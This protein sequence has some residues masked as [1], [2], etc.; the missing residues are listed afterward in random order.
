[1][2]FQGRFEIISI[3]S[4]ALLIFTLIPSSNSSLQQLLHMSSPTPPVLP[5]PARKPKPLPKSLIVGYGNWGQCDSKIIQAVKDGVN[6]VIWFS[7][8]LAVDSNK[9]PVIARGLNYSCVADIINKLNHQGYHDT[10]HLISIGGWNSP[11]PDTTNPVSKVYEMFRNWNH[12]LSR[13]YNFP[14]FDGIDWDIEG[15]DDLSSKYNTF[16]IEVLDFMGHFSQLAKRDG[17]IVS[18]APAESYL[19]P[20]TS[21]FDLSLKHEYNEWKGL[22]APFTYHGRNVYGYVLDRYGM[23]DLDIEEPTNGIEKTKKESHVKTFDFVT[24]QLYEGYSHALFQITKNCTSPSKFLCDFT[25]SVTNGWTINFDSV[26]E[27][28]W[29]SRVV[30]VEAERLVIGLANGWANN[31]KFLL[32]RPEQMEDGA[33]Q[34]KRDGMMVRGFAFWNIQDEGAVP[35]GQKEEVWLTKGLNKILKIRN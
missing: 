8:D 10:V 27:A 12:D 33:T 24:I 21:E 16:T 15:N 20:T 25:K 3:L 5:Y 32:I 34:L 9:Q 6:V 2:H 28:N 29:P 26:P 4:I 30:K 11:H 31:E 19:D 14:G 13:R 18:M 23:T 22:I 1:M 17:F 35:N 7:I